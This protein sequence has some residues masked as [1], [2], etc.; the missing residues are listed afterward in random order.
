MEEMENGSKKK[1]REKRPSIRRFPPS[2][3][4][5][6]A[7]TA[8]LLHATFD[9]WVSTTYLLTLNKR[10]LYE[11]SGFIITS[12]LYKDTLRPESFPPFEVLNER[13]EY[14]GH[15]WP[16]P[17]FH[18]FLFHATMHFNFGEEEREK[19]VFHYFRLVGSGYRH[20]MML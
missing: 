12:G 6:G 3:C 11:S 17:M 16:F 2:H 14:R 10:R 1:E 15:S 7:S 18:H 19:R 5:R 9:S 8:L 4:S 13:Y 20:D